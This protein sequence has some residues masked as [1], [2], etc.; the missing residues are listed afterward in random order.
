M[1]GE[2]E[3]RKTGVKRKCKQYVGTDRRWQIVGAMN[4]LMSDGRP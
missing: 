1:A 4:K 2:M 3:N